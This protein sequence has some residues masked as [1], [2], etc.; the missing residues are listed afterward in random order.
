MDI[1][2]AGLRMAL[3][4][5][6][7]GIN[8]RGDSQVVISTTELVRRWFETFAAGADADVEAAVCERFGRS[9]SSV[10]AARNRLTK[11]G[12]IAFANSYK[13]TRY[14]GLAAVWRFEGDR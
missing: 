2:Q 7:A 10:R 6:L 12:V 1:A 9:P 4:R 3:C 13:R 11:R 8:C 5:E 14:K